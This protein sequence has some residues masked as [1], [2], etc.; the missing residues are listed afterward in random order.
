MWLVLDVNMCSC[1][2]SALSLTHEP[3]NIKTRSK[4]AACVVF[5]WHH[6]GVRAALLWVDGCAFTNVVNG[7]GLVCAKNEQDGGGGGG[8]GGGGENVSFTFQEKV[9]LYVCMFEVR[10]EPEMVLRKIE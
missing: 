1:F 4:D 9:R 5:G 3:S 6:E 8:G 2:S 7:W 10:H